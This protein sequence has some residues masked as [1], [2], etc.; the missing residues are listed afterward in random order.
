MT[1]SWK[2]I[3]IFVC[4]SSKSATIHDDLSLIKSSS[5]GLQLLFWSFS[6]Y[7]MFAKQSGLFIHAFEVF[8]KVSGNKPVPGGIHACNPSFSTLRTEIDHRQVSF[9]IVPKS[10]LSPCK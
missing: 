7:V 1:T 4:S 6:C 10:N 3:C 5:N 2:K 9:A 8:S